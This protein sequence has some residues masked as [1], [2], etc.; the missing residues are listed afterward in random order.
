MAV[1]TLNCT[2]QLMRRA[3]DLKRLENDRFISID[4]KA[5]TG[6]GKVN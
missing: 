4:E 5:E 2:K 3:M 6:T 1:D